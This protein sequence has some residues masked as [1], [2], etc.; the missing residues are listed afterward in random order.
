MPKSR[1]KLCLGEWPSRV[2]PPNGVVRSERSSGQPKSHGLL[3]EGLR[4]HYCLARGCTRLLISA[5]DI[6]PLPSARGIPYLCAC[7]YY[8]FLRQ[9]L[10]HLHLVQLICATGGCTHVRVTAEE[11]YLILIVSSN[12]IV[13]GWR[14]HR[15]VC[16][17]L[18]GYPS[19]HWIFIES[20]WIVYINC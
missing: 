13:F 7:Y 4:R 1:H 2:H 20:R 8:F 19:L 14:K 5:Q 11:K 16:Y 18:N 10:N 9:F 6:A 15:Y 3:E 17:S 12:I